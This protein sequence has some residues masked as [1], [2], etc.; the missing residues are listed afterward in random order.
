L[1][2]FCK[3]RRAFKRG[4]QPCKQIPE[5]EQLV[6]L[7]GQE[8]EGSQVFLIPDLDDPEEMLPVRN[9]IPEISSAARL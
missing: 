3:L 1:G 7:V 2:P 6:P 9:C 5:D 8:S 4:I